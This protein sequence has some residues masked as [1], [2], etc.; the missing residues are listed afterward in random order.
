MSL[1][2]TKDPLWL[3]VYAASID[4]YWMENTINTTNASFARLIIKI[5][6]MQY[7]QNVCFAWRPP[8]CFD[9]WPFDKGQSFLMQADTFVRFF[10]CHKEDFL[11]DVLT[12]TVLH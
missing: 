7:N 2:V 6:K 3:I 4:V 8:T 1:D 11:F 5:Y 12:K 9:K 10:L